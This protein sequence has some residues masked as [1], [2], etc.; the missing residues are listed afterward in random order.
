[1]RGRLLC[2][3]VLFLMLPGASAAQTAEF[4]LDWGPDHPDLPRSLAALRSSRIEQAVERLN[5]LDVL[6]RN[7]TIRIA[8]TCATPYNSCDPVVAYEPSSRTVLLSYQFADDLL[9]M[10]DSLQPDDVPIGVSAVLQFFLGH[11]VGHALFDG[12]TSALVEAESE[13]YLADVM[14][15]LLLS[16]LYAGPGSAVDPYLSVAQYFMALEIRCRRDG[17][18]PSPHASGLDR[19]LNLICWGLAGTDTPLDSRAA[20]ALREYGRPPEGCAAEL[21]NL[22]EWINDEF[23]PYLRGG[24]R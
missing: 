15:F 1:M 14:G 17:C 18:T 20:E 11:E 16:E 5:A 2:T 13:E 9:R 12:D 22:Y 3:T 23:L 6:R 10:N 7:V 21:Q 4:R 19:A 24:Q 8:N